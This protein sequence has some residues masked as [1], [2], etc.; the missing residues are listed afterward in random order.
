MYQA[1]AAS[2]LRRLELFFLMLTAVS[3]F[4]GAIV[5]RTAASS[6]IGAHAVSWF[7]TGLFVL[8][9]GMRPWA[10]LV[11]RI[12]HR[13]S[14]LHDIVHFPA[15]D[16]TYVQDK[17]QEAE[18]AREKLAEMMKRVEVLE[19]A[20]GGVKAQVKSTREEVVLYVD[21]ALETV[22]RAG[23][24]QE[25]RWERHEGRVKEVENGLASVVAGRAI[26]TKEGPLNTYSFTSSFLGYVLPTWLYVPSGKNLY[27]TPYSSTASS[28][29]HLLRSFPSSSNLETIA[30]E[31]NSAASLPIL[32]QP[33]YLTSNILFR[34]GYVLTMPLRAAV[35]MALRNY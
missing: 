21:D 17:E 23:R 33:S 35:R 12:G 30:E 2:E 16:S 31:D 6:M 3:P 27:G 29:R 19:L 25:R 9:T 4:V 26:N 1:R 34:T 13:T 24:K 22:E 20:L 32:A 14:D 10:H 18:A 15:P 11:D 28:P 5:L 8:A 7:S